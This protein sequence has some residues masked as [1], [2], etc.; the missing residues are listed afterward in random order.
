[1]NPGTA[2]TK[3]DSGT[4][5]RFVPLRRQ[6]EVTS[7]GIN[8]IVLHPGQRGWIHRHD[9]QEEVYLVLEGRLSLLVEGD[10]VELEAGELIGSRRR[11]DGSSS[12]AVPGGS[13]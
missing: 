6:L 1:M 2:R 5:E 7:F 10:E 12:T 3:L 4:G 9:N 13:Y 8:Q 11:F